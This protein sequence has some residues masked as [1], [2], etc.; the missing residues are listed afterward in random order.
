MFLLYP[1]VETRIDRGSR[2]VFKNSESFVIQR[3]FSSTK[4]LAPVSAKAVVLTL[5]PLCD[6]VQQ[7]VK[8]FL[9]NS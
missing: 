9:L 5:Y 1:F 3:I 6:N 4:A 8:L 7:T 2:R